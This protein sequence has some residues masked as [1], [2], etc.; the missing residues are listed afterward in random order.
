[1]TTIKAIIIDFGGVILRTEDRKP[2][3]TLAQHHGLTFQELD[4]L[5]FS[6]VSSKQAAMGFIS[7]NQH[8]NQV[9]T[10][11]QVNPK[12]QNKFI[13]DFFAG[14]RLDWGLLSIL[15]KL[16]KKYR[17]ALLS[18]AWDDLRHHI[19]NEWQISDIFDML[20]ISAEVGLVKPDPKIFE[21]TLTKLGLQAIESI[22][23]DDFLE[24]I[25]TARGIGLNVIQFQNVHQVTE[26]LYTVLDGVK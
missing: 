4:D 5:V 22:F 11:L 23:I 21:Y 6:S 17:I 10:E 2:R 15:R 1:M 8:W 19:E 25:N 16:H 13:Q 24:N 9:C 18:N 3:T 7:S 12:M 20:V 14:D 26:D